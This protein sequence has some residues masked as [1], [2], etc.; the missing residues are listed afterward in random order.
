MPATVK[1]ASSPLLADRLDR[2]RLQVMTG[3]LAALIG[4]N[5]EIA[6]LAHPKHYNQRELADAIRELD[7]QMAT[8]NMTVSE[9]E[10]GVRKPNER[11]MLLLTQVFDR[12][13]DWFMRDHE[14]PAEETPDLSSEAMNPDQ[15]DL[16]AQI[17][18]LADRMEALRVE[19]AASALEVTTLLAEVLKRVE[20]IQAWQQGE[21][22]A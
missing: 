7:P 10:R 1:P 11:Y 6:R 5:I 22:N 12:P 8:S 13:V 9:W 19:T 2:L 14:A 20:E 17:T 16:Q 3:E 21:G 18:E 4:R 15:S